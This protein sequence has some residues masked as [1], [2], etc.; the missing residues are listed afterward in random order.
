[1]SI[2]VKT[3]N[4]AAPVQTPKLRVM[5]LNTTSDTMERADNI[6][7]IIKSQT[8]KLENLRT[9]TTS[10]DTQLPPRKDYWIDTANSFIRDKNRFSTYPI[11]Y[12]N[13]VNWDSS[14][15]C[16]LENGG[17]N[18]VVITGNDNWSNFE[19]VLTIKHTDSAVF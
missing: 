9:G 19:L 13:P 7:K 1:M 16:R 5:K 18:V 11:P 10:Y 8:I 4:G 6:S 2:Y 14:V 17:I 15:S 3:K 12:V